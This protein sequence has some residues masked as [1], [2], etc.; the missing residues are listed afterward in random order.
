MICRRKPYIYNIFLVITSKFPFF[1]RENGRFMSCR[2]YKGRPASLYYNARTR[3]IQVGHFHG[4]CDMRR[5]INFNF[6]ADKTAKFKFSQ[7]IDDGK[8][9]FKVH[10]SQTHRH[11]DI[12]YLNYISNGEQIKN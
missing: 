11:L 12:L 9:M 5:N 7:K 10:N 1:G 8:L 3:K 6:A 2:K 4:L